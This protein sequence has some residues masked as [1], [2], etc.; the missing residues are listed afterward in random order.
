MFYLLSFILGASVGSF[1]QVIATRLHVAPVI[2]GRSKCLSCGEALRVSDLIPVV[3]YFLLR[4]KCRYC[5]APYG[6]SALFIEALF[7]LIFVGLYHFILRM[8]PSLFESGLFLVYYTLVFGVLG[9]MALYDRVHSYVPIY[10]LLSFLVLT[11]IMYIWR[12]VGFFS[13]EDM[14]APLIVAL[15]F[16][17]IWVVTKGKG[18]GF[19]DVLLF[20]GVGAFFGVYAGLAVF[21]LSVWMGAVVGLLV[22]YVLKAKE[23][24]KLAIPFVPFI[25]FSFVVVLFTGID[26]FSIA[27]LFG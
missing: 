18:V 16:F 19:G 25:A 27:F 17:A 10:F 21:M 6:I 5:R 20:L 26:I 13:V 14:L 23:G 7:G 15:P 2:K 11:F 3:S 4:G 24:K 22:K 1:V 9:V 8:S 12:L